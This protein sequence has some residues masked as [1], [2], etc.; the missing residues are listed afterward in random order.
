MHQ[1]PSTVY[2]YTDDGGRS[3]V[4]PSKV[5]AIFEAAKKDLL[6]IFQLQVS[7]WDTSDRECYTQLY[8][9][10]VSHAGSRI[11][12][13]FAYFIIFCVYIMCNI[14]FFSNFSQFTVIHPDHKIYYS[15]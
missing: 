5:G 4:P 6:G 13:S 1:A 10:P 8:A 9:S 14:S 3:D 7:A 12:F 11:F 2:H 15:P